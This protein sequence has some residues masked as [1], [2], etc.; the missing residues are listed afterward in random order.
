MKRLLTL[1]SI[2]ILS[3]ASSAEQ[4]YEVGFGTN[5]GGVLGGTI[6]V[7]L[8]ANTE[9]FVGLGAGFDGVTYVVG[10]KF[11][12]NN[13]TR[14]TMN[15]GT[16]CIYETWSSGAGYGWKDTEGLNFGI[17]YT[18]SGKDEAGWAFDLM[19]LDTSDCNAATDDYYS[20]I[21]SDSAI[22]LALGYRF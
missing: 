11:W 18:F 16:N 4:N 10:T 1:I 7:D 14:L 5:Y 2:L 20:D 13:N 6:N 19:L 21:T 3:T 22:R 8:N 9:V 15:Y 12:L 17:G